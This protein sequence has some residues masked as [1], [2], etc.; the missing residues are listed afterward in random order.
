MSPARRW[1]ALSV[2]LAP[3][4][5]GASGAAAQTRA[6]IAD[7]SAEAAA[8]VGAA[9]ALGFVGPLAPTSIWPGFRPDTLSVVLSVPGVGWLLTAWSGELPE[10]FSAVGGLP[11]AAWR[12]FRTGEPEES[13]TI[14]LEGRPWIF[15]AAPGDRAA[16]LGDAVHEAFHLLQGELREA[17]RFPAG[18]NSFRVVSYPEFDA[19]N[20]SAFALEGRLLSAALDALPDTAAAAARARDFVAVRER[21]QRRLEPDD[22]VFERRAELNEGIAQY[23]YVRALTLVAG[24]ADDAPFL[25]MGWRRDAAAELAHQR[26]LLADLIG[27]RRQSIRLRFYATGFAQALLL[28]ALAGDAW[29][30]RVMADGLALQDLLAE[31]SGYRAR[32]NDLVA[33]ARADHAGLDEEAVA[34]VRTLRAERE[35][36]VR[37]VLDAAG[38]RIEVDGSALPGGGPGFCGIDPQNLLQVG[39]ARLLHA[40]W[41]RACGPGFEAELS[42]PVL[43]DRNAGTLVLVA[44]GEDVE[45]TVDGAPVTAG[46]GAGSVAIRA[47]GVS[48]RA[49][50]ARVRVTDEG[51]VV[52]LEGA[53]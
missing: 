30:A 31:A 13:N 20:E 18:E 17:G 11:G 1:L 22:A 10:G 24:S 29:K 45:V 34:A 12:A 4:L 2:G 9:E 14:R 42:T 43:Q 27:A 49:E 36:R 51:I 6:E 50:R 26:E 23:A 37:D 53:G 15:Y 28:D 38:T 21:R 46:G 52:V 41:F 39:D 35:R 7:L 8:G 3:A 5:A 33:G 32:E 19:E 47:E 16:T 44:P 25:D 40:R 48:I